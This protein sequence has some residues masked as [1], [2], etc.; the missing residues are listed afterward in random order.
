MNRMEY[1]ISEALGIIHSFQWMDG[2]CMDNHHRDDT[3]DQRVDLF[4]RS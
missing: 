2:I 3:S 1:G 4:A